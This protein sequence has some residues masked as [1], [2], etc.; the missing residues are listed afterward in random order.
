MSQTAYGS[1]IRES[2]NRLTASF[3]IDG[4]AYNF[5]ATVS[6]SLPAFTTNNTKLAYN[7]LDQLTSTRTFS[8]Q[9]GTT[10]FKLTFNNG[11]I[12]DGDLNQP[13]IVP[14][15]SVNGNGVWE[16]S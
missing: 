13:G 7:D 6:P 2:G 10:T 5:P 9:I 3:T 14:A 8:G 16:G 1:L 11:P 4:R 15:A 12:V